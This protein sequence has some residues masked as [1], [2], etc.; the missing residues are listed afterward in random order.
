MKIDELTMLT[1]DMTNLFNST[2]IATIFVD[3]D[4]NI[5]RF[6]E[7]TTKLIM[8]IESD[9]GRPLSDIVSNIKYPN[10]VDD[11]RQVIEKVVFK[12]KE[13]NTEE[14]KWYKVRIMPYKTSQNI[15]DGTTITFINVTQM[16]N[17]QQKMQSAINYAGDII[18]TVQEPLV[19]LDQELKVISAN[20]SFYD[21]FQLKKSETEGETLNK[22]G[23]GE[24]NISSLINL[25]EDAL[26][27]NKEMKDFELE[28]T[29]QKVGHKKM[30][31]NARRIRRDTG[32][33]MILLAMEDV[34]QKN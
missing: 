7:E 33:E 27:K 14:G 12:E 15:I 25:L 2:E 23:N 29:F 30:L 11:I 26:Q 9:V 5:R 19:V 32:A 17:I 21:I 13:V 22:I 34:K 6:T 8:L 24:W 18:N 1:D 31:L 16:K 10:L 28:H 20:R 3:N 4:L